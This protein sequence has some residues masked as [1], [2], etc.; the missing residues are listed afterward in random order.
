MA[1]GKNDKES[2]MEYE[3]KVLDNISKESPDNAADKGRHP[4][5]QNRLK[6]QENQK[7]RK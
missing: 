7:Q 6:D 1:L 2:L 4:D 5:Q 3:K